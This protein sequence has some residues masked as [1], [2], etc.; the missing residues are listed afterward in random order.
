MSTLQSSLMLSHCISPPAPQSAYTAHLPICSLL[1]PTLHLHLL[2]HA[3]YTTQ[4]LLL[5]HSTYTVHLLL[6]FLMLPTFCSAP[7]C[8]LH[9]TSHSAP[10]CYLHYTPS[11][12]SCY[13]HSALLPHAIYIPL[14]S[15]ML[16]N[17]EH[18]P[19]CC[20]YCLHR[21][22]LLPLLHATYT[23]HLPPCYI[24][25]TPLS[26]PTAQVTPS[27]CTP[28]CCLHCD[29]LALSIPI[30]NCECKRTGCNASYNSQQWEQCTGER[31]SC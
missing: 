8:Y 29:T 21:M 11:A 17:T 3:T 26:T 12:P 19:L 30:T 7:S 22:P 9:Y 1:L 10:S 23:T 24:H 6:C 25:C 18:L 5:P 15:L 16:T 28:I 20:P 13:L 4:P 14:C 27:I 2:P 31:Y